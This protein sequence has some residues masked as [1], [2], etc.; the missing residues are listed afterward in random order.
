MVR[1]T[2]LRLRSP[3]AAFR[4]AVIAVKALSAP[5]LKERLAG[6][7][8]E[9]ATGTPAQLAAFLRNEIAKRGKVIKAAGIRAE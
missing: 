2:P 4:S 3:F 6:E 5:D 9:R 8:A 1:R 7:G